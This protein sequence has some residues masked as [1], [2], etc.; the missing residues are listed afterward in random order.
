LRLPDTPERAPTPAAVLVPIVLRAACPTLLLTRRTAHLTDHAGQIAFPGGR[1]DE[2]DQSP[3]QTALR[4]AFEEVG[5]AA[6]HV[7][8][9]GRLPEYRTITQYVVTPV[10]ALVKPDFGLALDPF[11][12]DEAFEVP[13]EFLMNPANHQRREVPVHPEHA[14]G[15]QFWAMPWQ[16]NDR[17]YFIWGATAA[18]IR[19]LYR[20]LSA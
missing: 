3:E 2:G 18:M 6:H 16:A 9:L 5:L 14:S 11:E 13:L 17:E 12:V 15:R 1:R 8:I 10:V 19:N 7:E 20:L 4:E